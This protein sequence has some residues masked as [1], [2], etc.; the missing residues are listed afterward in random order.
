MFTHLFE[1]SNALGRH[2]VGP[3][4]EE[5]ARFLRHY[6][7]LGMSRSSLRHAAEYS[8]LESARQRALDP[9]NLGCHVPRRN[10]R[11][12][13]GGGRI[14]SFEVCEHHLPI[15]RFEPLNQAEE[16]VEVVTPET[17]LPRH[18]RCR[19]VVGHPINPLRSEH[20]LSKPAKLLH[21]AT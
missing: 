21:R 12:L 19:G 20:R 2:P 14:H 10:A 11:D 6:S 4:A 15:Q 17:E 5:R 1:R 16:P 8:L 9:V 7:A 3:F 13:G 18:V